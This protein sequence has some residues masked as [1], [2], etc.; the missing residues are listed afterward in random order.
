M[1][2]QQTTG[3]IKRG[4]FLRELGLSGSALMAFYCLGTL[5]SC[6]GND[7]Q[8]ATAPT[9]PGTTPPPTGTAGLTGN[10]L[11]GQGRINFTLDLTNDTYKNLKT[12]GNYVTPGDVFVANT[13]GGKLI[14]LSKSCPHAG[15]TVQYRSVEGDVYCPNHGSRFGDT[16]AVLNGPAASPLRMYVATLSAN[17]NSLVITE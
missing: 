11:T 14:A 10:A 2:N 7:P 5:S 15:T 6:S 17:G 4:E 12:A 8:P 16:G 1:E 13:K 3:V 9:T